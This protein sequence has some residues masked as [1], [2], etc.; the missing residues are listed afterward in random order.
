MRFNQGDQTAT[1]AASRRA[2]RPTF[3]RNSS[4]AN[5]RTF[6]ESTHQ[7]DK[8]SVTRNQRECSS[9]SGLWLVE[10]RTVYRQSKKTNNNDSATNMKLKTVLGCM[11]AGLLLTSMATVSLAQNGPGSGPKGRGY[12]GPPQSQAERNARQQAC[13]KQNGA[14]PAVCPNAGP[15]CSQ[16]QANGTDQGYRRGRRDGTG[17]RN[18]SGNCPMVAPKSSPS[19]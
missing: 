13:P 17:P 9:A 12:G 11:V 18:A 1:G 6:T 15:G 3:Y 7:K 14:C 16:G 5:R 10:R 19:K 8:H 2:P 4:R